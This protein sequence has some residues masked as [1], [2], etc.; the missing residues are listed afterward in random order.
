M[1]KFMA[2]PY[3]IRCFNNEIEGKSG[4]LDSKRKSIEQTLSLEVEKS[5]P[6]ILKHML[7]QQDE[8]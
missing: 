6:Q 8:K 4:V 7:K 3:V 5:N 2:E 1:Q